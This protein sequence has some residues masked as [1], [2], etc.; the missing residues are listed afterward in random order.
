MAFTSFNFLI[1]FPL[2]AV[3]Y[4]LTPAKFRWSLL[5]VASYFFYVN[6]KPVFALLLA[7]ITLCTYLFTRLMDETD[8]E[9]KKKRYMA[10]NIVLILL[11]LLFFKYFSK[12]NDGIIELLELHHIRWPL[13]EI[14][15]IL[16]VGISFYTFMAIGYTVDVY[17]EEIKA[18]KNLGMV[19]LFLSFFPLIL[20]GPIERAKNMLPQFNTRSSLN[21]DW[22]V[23][24]L[25]MMLWGYF[26]KLVVA[27]R[28]GIYIDPV[29]SKF[30]YIN[31][32]NLLIAS[33]FCPFQLY[34]DLGG[35]SLIAI[36][37]AK[38]LGINV[39]QNFNRPF[40]APSMAE[41]W[42]R[43]HI[44]LISWLTDYV[45][46][47]LSFAFRKYKLW[48]IALALL[49]TFLISG[50]WHG[51]AITFMIWGLIQGVFLSIEALTSKKRTQFETRHNLKNNG[52]YA[53]FGISFTFILFAASLIFG[54]A[55]NISDALII[56]KI[57]FST[58]SASI[59]GA[60]LLTVFI[61]GVIIIFFKNRSNKYSQLKFFVFINKNKI[62]G[63][64][65]IGLCIAVIL[66]AFLQILGKTVN[67]NNAP[68][69][70]KNIVSSIRLLYTEDHSTFILSVLSLFILLLK[71][72]TD[73][74]T[75]SKFLIYESKHKIVRVMAYSSTIILILLIG[76]LDGGQF[77]YFQF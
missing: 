66:F 59:I 48:G 62:I 3:L 33:I 4:W 51:A 14:K 52:F 19:A 46:T 9:S 26:M 30:S 55:E 25:K 13:P 39:M 32:T 23:Q 45:Y 74:F 20:S 54:K 6:T 29:Y 22:V 41:L 11:P 1:F 27:D 71:D 63:R 69:G 37:T 34:A 43:W 16:P 8:E 53:F 49:I 7:G 10:I 12:L 77:I 57:V 40:F 58:P 24:G 73:E 75:P 64:I 70:F 15:L 67:F 60:S 61:T 44:S 56:Y 38:I 5:L 35:Y 18:E 21:Y 36:G 28:L 2:V 76:V 68:Y 17:N 65:A 72:V 31:G 42:R 50:I 47:P